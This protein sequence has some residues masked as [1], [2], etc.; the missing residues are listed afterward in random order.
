MFVL[1]VLTGG[2]STHLA[3]TAEVKVKELSP[4]VDI[5]LPTE[6]PIRLDQKE[7]PE[8]SHDR[9]ITLEVY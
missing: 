3:L 4:I 5:I 7:E 6:T 1:G 9:L 2:G 8:R